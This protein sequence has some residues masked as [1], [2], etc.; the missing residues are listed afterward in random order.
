M[1]E[2]DIMYH[3]ESGITQSMLGAFLSCRQKAAFQLAGWEPVGGSVALVLGSLAHDVLEHMY[4]DAKKGKKWAGQAQ[5]ILQQRLAKFEYDSDHNLANP[6]DAI[7][8]SIKVEAMIKN[9]ITYYAKEDRNAEWL[10]LEHR[11]DVEFMGWRLRG[12]MDGV[13][14]VQRSWWLFETKTASRID[15]SALSGYLTYD[16]QNLFYLL[17]MELVAGVKLKGVIYNII[18]KPQLRLKKDENKDSFLIR[19]QE[20][21]VVRPSFYFKRFEI[22]YPDE[23]RE[24]FKEQLL[25]KLSDY[26]AW[27]AGDLKTYRNETACTA[28]WNCEFISACASGDTVGYSKTKVL[29]RELQISK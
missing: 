9:Y 28:R 20:D 2:N 6:Q 7:D 27:L 3:P 1:F 16:L 11:F 14:K 29:Y 21:I 15:E 19:I 24:E 12:M 25:A 18:R 17:A 10:A 22:F 8:I 5:A 23:V 13:R 4:R 26:A